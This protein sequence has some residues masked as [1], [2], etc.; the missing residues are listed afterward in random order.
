MLM[1]SLSHQKVLVVPSDLC[2]KRVEVSTPVL[3]FTKMLPAKL[4]RRLSLSVLLSDLDTYTRQRLRKK[5]TVTCTVREV[6]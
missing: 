2:S 5:Y 3:P 4:K 1:L 6:A